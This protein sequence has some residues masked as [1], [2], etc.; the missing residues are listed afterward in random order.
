MKQIN[1]FNSIQD[2]GLF[3]AACL[4]IVF[5]F[6]ACDPIEIT[7]TGG[8][9]PEPEVLLSLVGGEMDLDFSLEDYR[10][11]GGVEEIN[12]GITLAACVGEFTP[13]NCSNNCPPSLAFQF[14]DHIQRPISEM[15][16]EEVL[17]VRS[18]DLSMQ[19]RTEHHSIIKKAQYTGVQPVS[20]CW[21]YQPMQQLCDQDLEL[22]QLDGAH[23]VSY[24]I[25]YQDKLNIYES[26]FVED[27]LSLDVGGLLCM[28]P[29]SNGKYKFSIEASD[30]NAN[31][32]WKEGMQEHHEN[33]I[34][35]RP[36]HHEDLELFIY[37]DDY[38]RFIEIDFR[39][40]DFDGEERCIELPKREEMLVNNNASILGT[41]RMQMVI[42]GS[43]Y[44]SIPS[45]MSDD[46][47]NILQ[48]MDYA[49]DGGKEFKKLKI[50]GRAHL[51]NGVDTISL[52]N[53]NGD[54]F[55]GIED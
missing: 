40:N 29:R 33:S 55:V 48:I 43:K 34:T 38:L 4:C 14:L 5:C 30:P 24:E 27:S 44:T 1:M 6:S 26:F 35:F 11:D 28:E 19:A 13:V 54:I 53:L 23:F 17:M 16:W 12:A 10:I 20:F 15:M 2:F 52:S 46:E 50:N 18:Y 32:M 31:I 8:T 41:V 21:K 42:D 45:A 3:Y 49:E 36:S 7:E 25:E 37:T 39:D 9:D 22:D 51:T 47:I